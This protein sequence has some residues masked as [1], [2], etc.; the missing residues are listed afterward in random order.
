MRAERALHT[1]P[2]TIQYAR[3][4]YTGNMAL[5]PSSPAAM[6]ASTDACDAKCTSHR[7]S[8]SLL[9]LSIAPCVPSAAR[10]AASVSMALP[11]AGITISLPCWLGCIGGMPSWRMTVVPIAEAYAEPMTASASLNMASSSLVRG[12]CGRLAKLQGTHTRTHT[13]KCA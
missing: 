13:H 3:P 12:F 7:P 5:A 2:R 11:G 4:L 6:A 1:R 9:T 10:S 8:S